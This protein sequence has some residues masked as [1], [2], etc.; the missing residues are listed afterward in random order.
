MKKTLFILCL[1]PYALFAQ[2]PV[3]HDKEIE[4]MLLFSMGRTTIE[5]QNEKFG[6]K[7]APAFRLVSPEGEVFTNESLMGKVVV[8]DFWATWCGGC[9]MMARDF[10]KML[11]KF[12]KDKVQLLAVTYK[13]TNEELG[14]NYWKESEYSFPMTLNSLEFGDIIGA[15]H[16][17]TLVIDQ[18]GIFRVYQ[19]AW[20]GNRTEQL[21]LFISALIG[22]LDISIEG[23]AQAEE[24]GLKLKANYIYDALKKEN[25]I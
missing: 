18:N 15:G 21:E 24:E 23:A 22:T 3:Q 11:T 1:L 14:L 2:S 16:P 9:K 25:P 7:P 5:T 8:M 19:S 13:E 4:K 10:E 17:S 12:P 6:G 20:T